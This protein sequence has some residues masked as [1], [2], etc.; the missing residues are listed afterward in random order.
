V[1]K[2]SPVLLALAGCAPELYYTRSVDTDV[3]SP[4][5]LDVRLRRCR[6]GEEPWHADPKTVADLAIRHY[7]DVP[8]KA[9]PFNPRYYEVLHKPEW[10]TY[11]TR[12][13]RYPSGGEMRYRVKLRKHEEI[14]YPIQVSHY[15]VVERPEDKA[16]TLDH[17]H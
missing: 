17:N 2:F 12:G 14:W 3:P 15:K 13:Y 5:D 10:G 4:V 6:S 8:W 9:D 7:A 16:H 1:R 11:V